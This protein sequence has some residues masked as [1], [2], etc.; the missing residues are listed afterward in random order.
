[1]FKVTDPKSKVAFIKYNE[2]LLWAILCLYLTVI[3]IKSSTRIQQLDGWQA[4]CT[5]ATLA[6]PMMFDI[7]SYT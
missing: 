7:G 4:C 3:N 2:C 6:S 5:L 1:M